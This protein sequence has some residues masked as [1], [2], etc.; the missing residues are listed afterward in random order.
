MIAALNWGADLSRR[1]VLVVT[2]YFDDSGTHADA[3]AV[4]MAGYVARMGDWSRFERASDHLFRREHVD[5]FHG[6]DFHHGKREFEGWSDAKKLRFATEW[7]DIA[8]PLLLRGATLSVDKASYSK[9]KEDHKVA[10]NTSPY[11]YCLTL[12]LKHLCADH[13]VWTAIESEGLSLILESALPGRDKGLQIEFDRIAKLNELEQHFESLTHAPKRSS[14]AL[15]LADYLAY[16]SW[17]Q[18]DKAARG[19]LDSRSPFHDIAIERVY[20]HIGLAEGFKPNP[21]YVAKW[22]ASKRRSS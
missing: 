22:R 17:Q 4:T 16:F 7:F 2:G 14:R 11:G 18:S 19:T 1:A 15:Q 5:V 12:V 20:T 6:K 21:E 3:A 10:Q 13:D 9:A 8:A